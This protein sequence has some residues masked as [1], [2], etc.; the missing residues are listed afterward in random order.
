[1][2]LIQNPRELAVDEMGRDLDGSVFVGLG[3]GNFITLSGAVQSSQVQQKVPSSSGSGL[4]VAG[5]QGVLRAANGQLQGNSTTDHVPEGANKYLTAA[6]LAT[7]IGAASE[8]TAPDNT[9]KFPLVDSALRWMSWANVI[10]KLNTLY[11]TSGHNHDS[12]YAPLTHA[13]RHQSG[14]A[15]AI[16]LDDLAA[17]D[18]NTDL[19]ASTG[20]HGLLPKLGGG[21]TNY[22]R[23]DGSWATPPGTSAAGTVY[24]AFTTSSSSSGGVITYTATCT[25]TMSSPSAGERLYFKPNAGGTG[26]GAKFNGDSSGAVF[27][28]IA[29]SNPGVFTTSAVY[30][31]IHDGSVWQ[32]IVGGA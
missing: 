31:C 8:K 26:S 13:S 2:R 32:L 27:I 20:N 12:A 30:C 23:A 18:D 17:P 7:V 19:N 21:T 14:G 9:D 5:K 4:S 25:P 11:A 3:G 29:A 22:L 6:N 24:T 10:V 1:M 15:D 16:K 28:K